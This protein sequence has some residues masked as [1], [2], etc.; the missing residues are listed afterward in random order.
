[1]ICKVDMFVDITSLIN[2]DFVIQNSQ[3]K[4]NKSDLFHGKF[5]R[6]KMPKM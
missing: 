4:E 3:S 1:M 5:T 2:N 6:E